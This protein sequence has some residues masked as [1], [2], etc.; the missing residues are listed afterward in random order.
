MGF[1]IIKPVVSKSPGAI[2][3]GQSDSDGMA[4]LAQCLLVLLGNFT[5]GFYSPGLE[6]KE[7]RE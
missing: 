4:L 2:G 7:P 3:G 6:G 1:C 5:S